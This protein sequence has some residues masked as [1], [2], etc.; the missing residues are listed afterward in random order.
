MESPSRVDVAVL[1]SGLGCAGAT[2]GLD[3]LRCFFHDD[4]TILCPRNFSPSLSCEGDGEGQCEAASRMAWRS[5]ERN[6]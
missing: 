3:D 4:S 6:P 1:V 5:L 2:V